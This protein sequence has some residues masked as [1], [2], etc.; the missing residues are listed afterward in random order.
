MTNSLIFSLK[1][2]Y[3]LIRFKL[4]SVWMTTTLDGGLYLKESLL[5][6][7]IIG[8]K[9]GQFLYTRKDIIN[10]EVKNILESLLSSNIEHSEEETKKM[11]SYDK[12][13]YF[14]DNVVSVEKDSLG[15][16]SLAQVHICYLK[17]H[18]G[19][20]Y[21]LK[22]AHP[23]IFELEQ[24]IKILKNILNVFAKFKKINIDWDSFF[25]NITVQI[26]LNNE[27]NN[28]KKFY[29]IYKN[30]EK[31]TIPELIYNDKYFIIMTFC[32]GVPMNKLDR[33]SKEYISATNLL[34]S[35]FYH[36][37]YKY[38]I[39]HGDMHF[40]NIL[41]K[42]N[43]YISLIDF[44]IC[45]YELEQEYIDKDYRN[46]VLYNYRIFL[47][48]KNTQTIDNLLGSIIKIPEIKTLNYIKNVTSNFVSYLHNYSNKY[49][50]NTRCDIYYLDLIFDFCND[51]NLEVNGVAVYI[52][53]QLVVLEAFAGIIPPN[54]GQV[55]IRTMSYMKTEPFFMEEMGDFIKKF[56]NLE[57]K[58][59]N[60]HVREAYP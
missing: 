35:C 23:C 19:K 46:E 24:E 38:N 33:N 52:I 50:G 11:V 55:N 21:V 12:T 22:V 3:F 16:G 53:L 36:T 34:S 14:N 37:I 26:D 48:E 51:Y 10:T 8:I 54:N 42:P 39:C 41:V 49:S 45:N 2:I 29:N 6:L 4:Y 15:S 27:A 44:G 1:W 57:Y 47:L 30:Y 7:G 13:N 60:S 20:K 43:G 31:I 17:D 9:F 5:N 58:H 32:E 25:K 40:G 18:P 28:M 59:E 56:Y